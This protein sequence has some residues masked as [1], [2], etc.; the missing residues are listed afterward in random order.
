M[1]EV[2]PLSPPRSVTPPPAYT[3]QAPMVAERRVYQRRSDQDVF[4]PTC[5][6]RSVGICLPVFCVFGW[7]YYVSRSYP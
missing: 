7:A 6:L 2:T 1:S 5:A 3:P 4:E